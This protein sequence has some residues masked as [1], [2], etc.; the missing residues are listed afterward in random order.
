MYDDIR[1]FLDGKD[2]NFE[3]ELQAIN[4]SDNPSQID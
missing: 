4:N 1:K 3:Q 2:P